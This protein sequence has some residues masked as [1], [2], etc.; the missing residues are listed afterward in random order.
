MAVPVD[1]VP[2]R[3]REA[4]ADLAQ[5]WLGRA[6]VVRVRAEARE[7]VAAG[8]AATADLELEEVAVRRLGVVARE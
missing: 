1:P 7:R 2:H 4:A 8:W 3:A 6:P 5:V